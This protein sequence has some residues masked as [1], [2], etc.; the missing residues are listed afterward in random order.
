MSTKRKL[1]SSPDSKIRIKVQCVRDH[2]S[3]PMISLHTHSLPTAL[4]GREETY[5]INKFRFEFTA[6]EGTK[7]DSDGLVI[8]TDP[9]QEPQ[10]LSIKKW[11]KYAGGI[12]KNLKQLH[13]YLEVED[14]AVR[15]L[16]TA[17]DWVHP[18]EQLPTS[19]ET[20]LE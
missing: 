20:I 18:L 7:W 5:N 2:S 9:E 14:G 15:F 19:E 16:L 3:G 11:R 6:K 1:E 8:C 4:V 17:T 10:Q 13:K 12:K